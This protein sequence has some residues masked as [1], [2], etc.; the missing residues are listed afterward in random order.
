MN[1]QHLKQL[2]IIPLHSALPD[3]QNE[4]IFDKKESGRRKMIVSTNIAESSI[5]VPDIVYVIDFVLTKETNYNPYNSM[6]KLELTWASQASARQRAGRTGRVCDGFCF[7]LVPEVFYLD[8]LLAFTTPELLRSPLDKLILRIKTINEDDPKNLFTDPQK[9]L[10]RAIQPPHIDNISFAMKS[11]QDAG[12]LT[13]SIDKSYKSCMITQLGKIY[14]DLPCDIRICKL[15]IMGFIFNCLQESVT[16]ASIL[17]HQKT[18]FIMNTRMN[19]RDQS[20]FYKN[21]SSYDRGYN[22]DLILML[23][24]FNEWEERFGSLDK[25]RENFRLN[26]NLEKNNKLNYV[27]ERENFNAK[28]LKREFRRNKVGDDEVKWCKENFLDPIVLREILIQREDI[29]QRLRKFN[30]QDNHYKSFMKESQITYLKLKILF[31]A[32]FNNN[33]LKAYQKWD[34]KLEKKLFNL[35]TSFNINTKSALIVT[36]SGFNAENLT[37]QQ[38][39]NKEN[40]W[41]EFFSF[42]GGVEK[43]KFNYNEAYITFK[44]S[45]SEGAIKYLLYKKAINNALK[46]IVVKDEIEYN[47][48]PEGIDGKEPFKKM[49]GFMTSEE[50]EKT[51]LESIGAFD[52]LHLCQFNDLLRSHPVQIDNDSINKFVFS[53]NSYT[54]TIA[55]SNPFRKQPETIIPEQRQEPRILIC[56][57][58]QERNNNKHY[59][60]YTTLLPDYPLLAPLLLLIFSALP[61]VKISSDKYRYEKVMID[62]HE[63]SLDYFLTEKDIEDVNNLRAY[64]RDN[65]TAEALSKVPTDSFWNMLLELLNR[66]RVKYYEPE[67]WEDAF[68]SQTKN[69]LFLDN[70]LNNANSKN[71]EPQCVAKFLRTQGKSTNLLGNASMESKKIVDFQVY[72]PTIEKIPLEYTSNFD[73]SREEGKLMYKMYQ[74]SYNQWKLKILEEINTHKKFLELKQTFLACGKCKL[75]ISDIKNL[76][77]KDPEVFFLRKFIPNTYDVTTLNYNLDDDFC[78]SEQYFEV[79]ELFGKELEFY[80]C[81]ND[82]IIGIRPKSVDAKDWYIYVTEHSNLI[83][84]YPDLTEESFDFFKFDMKRVLELENFKFK[85]KKQIIIDMRYDCHICQEYQMVGAD[86]ISHIN[87]KKHKESLKEF[88]ASLKKTIG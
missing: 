27:V 69:S 68:K 50:R 7:R 32:S 65:L 41:K 37:P 75:P 74:D 61:Q 51:F 85:K 70:F 87:G 59:T 77:E 84:L 25:K 57:D 53:N 82:H 24:I 28:V 58:Y 54:S 26:L 63:V 5:T 33:F 60:R 29:K 17:Q 2:K 4:Q 44:E 46:P 55:F 36:Y 67:V 73:I 79:D 45:G 15:C 81:R 3:S 40:E 71:K 35:K 10:G 76:K 16:I 80:G 47:K 38:I 39:I 48:K 18:M 12:A 6:E 52:Y 19:P 22:S 23:N 11:L 62:E 56:F 42:Y 66:E 34:L 64:L 8:H 21:I 86:F 72:L 49:P 9:V 78:S 20:K 13:W 1:S 83:V 31:A 88:Q 43:I 14:C 30:F